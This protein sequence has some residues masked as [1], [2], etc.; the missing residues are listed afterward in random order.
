MQDNNLMIDNLFSVQH[1]F[2]F[3]TVLDIHIGF[4][5]YVKWSSFG[6][7]FIYTQEF[8]KMQMEFITNINL[9]VIVTVLQTNVEK[10]FSLK[11]DIMSNTT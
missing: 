6:G 1:I 3:R 11:I 2:I 7:N 10:I 5:V 9:F 4:W 8:N